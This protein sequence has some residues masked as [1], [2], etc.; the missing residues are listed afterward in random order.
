MARKRMIKPE[1]FVDE[2]IMDLP[3]PARILFIGMWV[4]ADDEGI[5]KNS[6]KQLKVQIFPSDVKNVRG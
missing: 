4:Y 2:R 5:F 6:P 3:I 1:F